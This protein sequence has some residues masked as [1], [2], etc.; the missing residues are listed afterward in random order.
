[1]AG[2]E[3]TFVWTGSDRTGRNAQG[4]INAPS[5]TIAKA[6]LRRQG[7]NAKRVRK[8]PK[9][10]FSIGQAIKPADI[11]IFTRQLATM[12]KAGVPMVQGIDIVMEGTDKALMKDLIRQ[13]RN[14]VSGGA[15]VALSMSKH[16]KYFDDLYCSLISEVKTRGPW[17]SCS[18]GLPSTKKRPKRSKLRSKRL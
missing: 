6:Q 8:K 9:P 4:E 5:A 7:I 18:I 12:S 11:A 13:I 3:I 1:M 14:D 10:L 17:R 2:S 15:P 16:D